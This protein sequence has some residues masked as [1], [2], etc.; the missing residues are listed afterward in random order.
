MRQLQTSRDNGLRG[1]CSL[2]VNVKISSF[3]L[4]IICPI[5]VSFCLLTFVLTSASCRCKAKS[6]LPLRT[7]SACY[8][9]L[10]SWGFRLLHN[11]VGFHHLGF[12]P[13]CETKHYFLFPVLLGDNKI[14]NCNKLQTLVITFDKKVYQDCITKLRF[15]AEW[16]GSESSVKV[17]CQD[18][19]CTSSPLS[20]QSM[21]LFAS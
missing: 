7:L 2:W 6:K 13:T 17:K 8:V 15:S 3:Q 18:F 20:S 1:S 9:Q 14:N 4:F 10:V 11:C 12:P 21:S 5:S 16:N 19:Q